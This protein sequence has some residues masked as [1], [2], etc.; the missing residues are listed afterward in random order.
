MLQTRQMSSELS[1]NV[2]KCPKLSLN[3]PK[4]PKM[5]QNFQK[6]LKC[7]KMSQNDASLSE[8]TCY[9]ISDDFILVYSLLTISCLSRI[10]LIR[11]TLT[12]ETQDDLLDENPSAW[13]LGFDSPEKQKWMEIH[14]SI[15]GSWIWPKELQGSAIWVETILGFNTQC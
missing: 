2:P 12:T 11:L 3:V 14:L 15:H 10:F 8:W 1:Q 13:K 7:P 6:C 4:C 5:S 9:L